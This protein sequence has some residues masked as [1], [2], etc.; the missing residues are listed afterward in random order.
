MFKK[1]LKDLRKSHRVTQ[2][3]LAQAIHVTPGNVGDWESGKSLP[4]YK[5]LV[6]L[7]KYFEVDSNYLLEIDKFELRFPELTTQENELI[8]ILR[9]L[10]SYEIDEIIE[11]AKEKYRKAK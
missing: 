5:A 11:I 10:N 1:V 4:S 9:E 7:S 6:A 8:R 3:Q 2:T